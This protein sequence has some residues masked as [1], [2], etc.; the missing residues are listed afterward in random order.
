MAMEVH[1][2]RRTNKHT[3][4]ESKFLISGKPK[5]IF[6]LNTQNPFYEYFFL[7]PTIRK[8]FKTKE[9]WFSL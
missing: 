3:F 4:S 2:Y 7:R 5:Q 1:T 8:N 9:E 6:L